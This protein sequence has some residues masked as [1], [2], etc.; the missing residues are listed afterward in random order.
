M[1][2]LM[3]HD[4]FGQDVLAA[5]PDIIGNTYEEK[6]AFLLGCQGPDPFFFLV[7]DPLRVNSISWGSMLHDML[8]AE[9]LMAFKA[10]TQILGAEERG[11]GKAYAYGYLCHFLLDSGSHPLVYSMEYRICD[12]G[13]E[14]LT[15]NDKTAV[16]H[17][18]ER[19]LDEEVLYRKRGCTVAD[20]SPH[21][22]ILIA[23]ESTLLTIA[24]MYSYVALS[25]FSTTMDPAAFPAAVHCY[26][27][28]QKVLMDSPTGLKRAILS[29]IEEI[30]RPYS[31]LRCMAPRA[32]GRKPTWFDNA[33]RKT[34][35]NPFTGESSSLSFWDIYDNAL[36]QS[37]S[38]IALFSGRDYL[39]ADTARSI[40]NDVNFLG[41]PVEA[42]LTVQQSTPADTSA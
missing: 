35:E 29:G 3:V 8:P 15:R 28:S 34:W 13:V 31:L 4:F 20:Y 30:V 27:I 12:A 11:V 26:S 40:T 38:A 21:E 39:D 33:K 22:N 25:V 42:R 9:Q 18:I 17:L 14:G 32:V 5:N 37:E 41:D 16:H 6:E 2:A 10:S 19:E 1:P 24:K 7:F 23:D 36:S